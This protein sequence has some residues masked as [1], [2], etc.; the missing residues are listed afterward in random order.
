MV[1]EYDYY[2]FT[3]VYSKLADELATAF[4]TDKDG[5][6]AIDTI[7]PGI[8]SVMAQNGVNNIW[9]QLDAPGKQNSTYDKY[10]NEINNNHPVVVLL[11]GSKE[12]TYMY[13]Q[14]FGNHCCAGVGYKYNDTEKFIVVHDDAG[15]GDVYCDFNSP[16]LGINRWLYIH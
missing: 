9:C 16:N 11:V 14:G 3:P 5:N 7:I 12:T 10:V 13:P 8:K 4:E 6:T 1:L 15:E 2:N